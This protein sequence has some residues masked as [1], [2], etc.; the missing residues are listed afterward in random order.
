MVIY[1]FYSVK[2][3]KKERLRDHIALALDV[4]K[5]GENSK[6]I[7]IGKSL[8]K[9]FYKLLEYSAVFHDFGKVI[10]NQY[11]FDI[12]RDLSFDG[13]EIISCWGA[14]EYFQRL[15]DEEEIKG[16]DR[17]IMDLAILLHH[18]PMNLKERYERL[19][20]R[21]EMKVDS[22]T[23]NLFYEEL[24][25]IV[26]RESINVTKDVGE[27][28]EEVYGRGGLLGELWREI[29]MNANSEIRKT[30]LLVTQALVAADNYSAYKIRGGDSKFINVV[31]M[32]IR[33]Y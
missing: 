4:I 20:M 12:N 11:C 10:H 30:F 9:N 5:R 3:N 14:N 25:E 2:E 32:F 27:V 1:S 15:V 6:L 7:R 29:W 17:E 26:K 33:F 23:F 21:R 28:C 31:N 13:H 19:R 18:H 24:G 16:I 8:N 22:M